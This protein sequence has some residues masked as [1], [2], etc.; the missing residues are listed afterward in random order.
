MKGARSLSVCEIQ[1][2]EEALPST[3]YRCL[4]ILGLYTGF[5]I[6]ELLSLKYEDCYS[7][8]EVRQ[9]LRVSRRNMKGG[10]ASRCVVLHPTAREYLRLLLVEKQNVWVTGAPLFPVS[11]V[12]AHRVLKQACTKAGISGHVSTHSMRK[13]FAKRVYEALEGDLI[14]TQTALGHKSINSTVS[15]LS[16]EQEKIDQAILSIG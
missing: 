1:A 4:F 8:K 6:S 2:I 15:Y 11:R 9:S 3:Q 14:G 12:Q 7:T 5:R 16:L 10:M 13:T